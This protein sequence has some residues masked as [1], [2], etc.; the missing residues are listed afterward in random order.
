MTKNLFLKVICSSSSL[1]WMNKNYRNYRFFV[2]T[3]PASSVLEIGRHYRFSVN[4]KTGT[5]NPSPKSWKIRINIEEIQWPF[6]E[7]IRTSGKFYNF[8]LELRKIL[9]LLKFQVGPMNFGAVSWNYVK[10]NLH[11]LQPVL[12]IFHKPVGPFTNLWVNL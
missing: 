11:R 5:T 2:H 7:V 8:Y 6:G 9:I 4:G 12:Q 3:K 10:Y 1:L